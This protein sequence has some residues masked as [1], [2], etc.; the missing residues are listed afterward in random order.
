MNEFIHRFEPGPGPA[1]LLAL[2]GTGGDE[3]D[4]LPLAAAVAP[5]CPVLSPRG[6]VSEQGMARFFRRLAPGV[7]DEDDIRLRATELRAWVAEARAHYELGGL[8]LV[9]LG[10]SNGANMAAALMLLHPDLLAGAILLS[11]MAPF[12]VLPAADLVGR[13]VFIGAGRAD[14]MIP[15]PEVLRLEKALTNAGA[16]VEAFWHD[17]GHTLTAE[18]VAAAADWMERRWGGAG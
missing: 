2:H 17:R 14:R 8:P 13:V 6:R 7:L 10:F 3:A 4:L 18:E 16:D 11:P 15:P 1:A 5:T 12:R 9:A